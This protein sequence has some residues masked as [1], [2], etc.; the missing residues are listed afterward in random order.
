[1]SFAKRLLLG[2]SA[3]L[4]AA[5]GAEAAETPAKAKPVQYVKICN[6]Y[7]DGF[8]SI[9]G[10]DTCLKLGGYLRVQAEYN[11]G[12][13]GIAIGNGSAEAA[14]ARTD[15]ASTNDVNFRTRGVTSWDVRQKTEYGDLR[16]F[17]R[18]G[19]QQ[20]T[21]ADAEGGVVY[22]DRAFTQFAGFT[23]GKTLSFFD[24]FTYNGAYSYHNARVSG[25]TT[26]SNGVTI[27]AY[28]ADFGNGFS[29]TLS[30]ENPGGHQRAP[31]VDAT[32][33][34]FF[35][36]NGGITGDTAFAQN[37]GNGFRLPDVVAN[38]RVD[39]TSGFVG[40]S[41]VVHEAGGAYWGT[42]N[43]VGNGHP[44]DKLGWALAAG[45]KLNLQ[46]GDI[47]GVNACYAEGASG[48][49]TNQGSAQVYNASTSVGA[50][51]ITD[52]VFASGTD[53][54]LTRVWSVLA[55]YEHIWGPRWRTSWYGG[56]VNVDY[57]DTATGIL[58]SS[59]VAGSICARP[60]GGLVGNL[61]AVSA[62]A[63]NSCN[64]DYSFFEAGSRTQWN[65]VPQ[66][67]IGLDVTYTYHNT[68]YKGA[69]LYTANAPRPAVAL[70]DD[71]NVWSA[72]FRWQRNFYP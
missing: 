19:I 28:T 56:Y 16:T 40:V 4:T 59:L 13:G 48:Y 26:I 22:W 72:F 3:G 36:V 57:N 35:A 2:T 6:G 8:H 25:D 46:G 42:A 9:P 60:F 52:G 18:I 17:I 14:Q 39:K 65:P 31:V 66:L 58:N 43:N 54:Q 45:A 23:V 29:A 24:I 44:A 68:A 20:T 33:A 63:G 51:W 27:W 32:V 67:D 49:C 12:S 10:T 69:G 15:R 64:P 70:I 21:P 34:G 7:G 61:S 37:A 71:Q 53:V 11:A 62:G 50:G 41:A 47:V 38:L 30:L 5:A 55:A 1:M